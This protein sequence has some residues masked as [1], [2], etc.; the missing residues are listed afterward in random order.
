[1]YRVVKA[2]RRQLKRRGITDLKASGFNELLFGTGKEHSSCDLLSL[3]CVVTLLVGMKWAF[4][5][6]FQAAYL[7]WGMQRKHWGVFAFFFAGYIFV[8]TSMV[9]GFKP[10]TRI[11]Q[12]ISDSLLTAFDY[13]FP[14]TF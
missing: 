2:K 12:C 9:F 13:W 11:F 1:M 6:D 8:H 7:H 10:A 3:L 14:G 4:I 5:L